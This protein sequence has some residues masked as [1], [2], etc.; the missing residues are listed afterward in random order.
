MKKTIFYSL[1]TLAALANTSCMDDTGFTGDLPER[2][3]YATATQAVDDAYEPIEDSIYFKM[4]NNEIFI[5]EEN[6]SAVDYKKLAPGRRVIT[7]VTLEDS[8]V[9]AYDYTAQLYEVITVVAGENKTVTTSEESDEI[10]DQTLSYIATQNSLTQGYLNL[11][12]GFATSKINDVEFYLVE[13][14]VASA[15]SSSDYL[16]LE[17]RFD[18]AGNENSGQTYERYVSFD[19][20]SFRE[21]LIDKEG[22]NLRVK[23]LK[24]GT[25]DLE[26][27]SKN[28]FTE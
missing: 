22:I 4:D 24:S 12:I 2:Y 20:E 9:E 17:L 6:K 19:L 11:F 18:S 1:F 13:N 10:A 25:I 26:I 5:I 16:N 23:T 28:L 8:N 27:D 3:T 21:K 15:T 7:G 14:L